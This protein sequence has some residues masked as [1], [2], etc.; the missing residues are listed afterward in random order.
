VVDDGWSA[1]GEAWLPKTGVRW[2]SEVDLTRV[3]EAY[4]QVEIAWRIARIAF[5]IA[6][7]ENRITCMAITICAPLERHVHMHEI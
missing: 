7:W 4:R 2:R 1:A 3:G 6:R 5:R